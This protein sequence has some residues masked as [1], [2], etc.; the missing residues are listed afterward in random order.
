VRLLEK[1]GHAVVVAGDGRKALDALER[2]AFDLVLMDVQMPEMDG[3]EATGRLRQREQGTSRHIPVIAMTAHAMKGDAERCLAAGMDDYVSKPVTAEALDAVLR[4]WVRGDPPAVATRPPPARRPSSPAVDLGM[5]QQ[6]RAAQG[7]DE[8][9]IVAEVVSLF[10]Q[11]A[12]ER[13]ATL[14]VAVERGDLDLAVRAAHTLKGSAGHLGAKTLAMICERFERKVRASAPFNIA[15]AVGA[16][17]DELERV[18][19]ALVDET[20]SAPASGPP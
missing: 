12:P 16:I 5:L 6:M 1:R 3:L 10:L 9:D 17:A 20:S 15:F 14:Q 4:R 13:L 7:P 2:E 11:D 18:R 19:A 8:A